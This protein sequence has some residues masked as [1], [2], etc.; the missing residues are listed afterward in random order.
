MPSTNGRAPVPTRYHS[1][2]PPRYLTAGQ[3]AHL[4]GVAPRTVAKWFGT[5]RL[6]GWRIPGGQ[7]R[8]FDPVVVFAFFRANGMPV[9]PEFA[10][11][12]GTTACVLIVSPTLT[13]DGIN[14][15]YA[16]NG[17]EAG[18]LSGDI[19]P[20]CVVMD[21]AGGRDVALTIW[22][23]LHAMP[24]ADAARWVWLGTE[25]EAAHEPPPGADEVLVG[26]CPATAVR[27]AI[28]GE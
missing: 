13:L 26:P 28:C 27:E 18:K 11:L 22:H 9:S 10:A 1:P 25:D 16:R 20:T 3:V 19:W 5:G 6:P 12:V 4:A 7:D 14:A 21:A 15:V 17:F 24:W 8:R 23:H 2:D